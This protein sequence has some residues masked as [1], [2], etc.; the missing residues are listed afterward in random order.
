M[1]LDYLLVPILGVLFCP[2]TLIFLWDGLSRL[3]TSTVITWIGGHSSVNLE[4][5]ISDTYTPDQSF[6]K[7][8]K[9]L[10]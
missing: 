10:I 5:W 4:Y 6:K 7:P 9:H 8:L 2:Y 1:S 3:G